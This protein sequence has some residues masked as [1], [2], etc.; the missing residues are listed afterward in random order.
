MQ[1]PFEMPEG[2]RRLE[3]IL[4]HLPP[5][6][7]HWNEAQNRFHFVDRLLSECLGWEKP[8]IEV[9][10]RNEAGGIADY[11]LGRPCKAVLEAKR[12]SI[13][14]DILPSGSPSKIR[15]LHPLLQTSEPLRQAV[16]QAIAY[17]SLKGAQLGIVCN[18]PQL[19][20]FQA[21]VIGQSPLDGECFLF[22]GFSS[23]SENFPL[24]WTLLSPEGVSENQ[25]NR[26]LSASRTPRIPAK[27]STSISN[28]NEYR[29]RNTFQE[30]LW[31]L[32]SILLEEIEDNPSLSEAFY[33]D[34][35]VP[36][37]ANN[38][39]LQLSKRIIAARYSR[40]GDDSGKPTALQARVTSGGLKMAEAEASAGGS[41]PVVVVGDI[42]VGKSS[43]FKNL[44]H[45][46][47][48]AHDDETYF[49]HIDLGVK[50]TLE[51]DIKSFVLSDIPRILKNEYGVDID[52]ADFANAI[53]HAELASFDKGVKGQLKGVNDSAYQM[54]RI[55]FLSSLIDDRARH[56][57]AAF[58]HLARGRNKRI[59]V[60]LDN[61]DQRSFD[62]QQEAFL[63]AQE[64]AASRNMLVFAALRPST[65]YLS[66]TTGALAAY[67][68]RVFTISPPPAEEVIQKRLTFALRVAE[69]KVNPKALDHI[70]LQLGNVVAFLQATLRSIRTNDSIRQFLS[71]ITGG[72][73]RAVIE[74]TTGF[75][76][77][78][79]VDSQKIVRIE[80]EHHNYK[81]PLHEFTKHA[82]LGEYAH[83]NA[84]SSQVACN[85]F[86]VSAADPREHFLASLIVAY[87]G[88]TGA[89]TDKDG[90]VRGEAVNAEML[91]HGFLEDQTRWALERLAVKR[92]IETPHG[93][94]RE[95]S[96]QAAML[97]DELSFRVTTIGNYHLRF[98]TGSFSYLDA[99]S[100]DTPIFSE[101]DR[102][103]VSRVA[104]SFDIAD[105]LKRAELFRAYL[106]GQW[107]SA[108][109]E[110]SYYD[111]NALLALQ[112]DTF[113]SVQ[114][115]AD[116]R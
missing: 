43:F 77:S 23:Y 67:Q 116:A 9:E 11:L 84:R 54:E 48:I 89:A 50:A 98:W 29:Y 21:I 34:C 102:D 28:P 5:D 38:R 111:F 101:G 15:K 65:F 85:L 92:L 41:R 12:P 82:L 45:Q 55:N 88:T 40:V 57:T 71:N 3:Q 79:N 18:G 46:L 80:L 63:I 104:D 51:S 70:R 6:N 108:R 106:E 10:N 7:P 112:R 81:V 4:Q 73:T 20:I 17:C 68:N 113:T 78:P 30:N 22:N 93:H 14:F 94:Y 59:I 74:L 87:L 96:V 115:A 2:R 53:Y 26:R 97:P 52:S 16:Q 58:G 86:D 62:V 103:G 107:D 42:G 95:L 8:D 72:N 64:L 44:R 24:L 1:A 31:S 99:M 13:V 75:F 69:G 25:A 110:A 83:Y 56:L 49:I 61:A 37:E 114:R 19:I 36:I 47:N 100:I 39:H 32:S 27:A 33:E 90:Y 109:V 76:G 60:V 66:K 105:R 91:R 35:Y